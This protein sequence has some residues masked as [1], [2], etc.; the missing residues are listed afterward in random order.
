MLEEY[1]SKFISEMQESKNLIVVE[2]KKDRFALEKSGLE[3]IVEISG[4]GLEKVAD[5]VQDRRLPV[6]ILTDFDN[7]GIKQYTRLEKLLL[8]AEIKVDDVTRHRFKR[9]FC[10]NK[11][12]EINSYFK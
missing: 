2:G 11:I 9:T 8:Q 7:E 12:E 1:Q 10:V 4:K 3:N 5:I 6:T